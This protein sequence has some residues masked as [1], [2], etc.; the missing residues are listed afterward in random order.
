MLGCAF[1]APSP[2]PY[3]RMPQATEQYGQVL[4]VSV[5]RVS[6][7]SRT[8]ASAGPGEKPIIA[9]LKPTS[10][11][12]VT[13]RNWRLFKSDMTTLLV[14]RLCGSLG[15]TL[16]SLDPLSKQYKLRETQWLFLY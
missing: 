8:S 12:P 13:F 7:Y 6:L 2:R 4:R 11:I 5:A 1:L 16:G 9:R 10:D 3:I 15:S 14:R